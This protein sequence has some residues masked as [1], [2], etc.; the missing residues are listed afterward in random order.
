VRATSGSV[1]R[2]FV[3]TGYNRAGSMRD[4][5][6]TSVKDLGAASRLSFHQ[7]PRRLPLVDTGELVLRRMV[8]VLVPWRDD[9]SVGAKSVDDEH[10]ELIDRINRLYDQLMVE[11]EPQSVSTIFGALINSITEHFVRE[12]RYMRERG[13]DTLP[14]H[15][16][17]YERLLDDIRTFFDEFDRNEEAGRGDLAMR[18]DDWL[19]GHFETHDARLGDLSG[20]RRD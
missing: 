16:E 6:L 8:M 10:K 18:L 15:R 5:P 12:E 4:L 11:E 14:Q 3:C 19:L 1:A 7:W 2:A 13:Y 17:D 20:R 9:Y